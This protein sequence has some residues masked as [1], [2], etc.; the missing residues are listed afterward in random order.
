MTVAGVCII[1]INK[2]HALCQH[3]LEVTPTCAMSGHLIFPISYW[4]WKKHVQITYLPVNVISQTQC[5]ITVST[6]HT[7]RTLICTTCF[8]FYLNHSQ[9]LITIKKTL[10]IQWM[11]HIVFL[12]VPLIMEHLTF[13]IIKKN[14]LKSIPKN[15]FFTNQPSS[16]CLKN[17]YLAFQH[18]K[19]N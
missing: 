5:Y 18:V 8:D 3:T 2:W 6:Q 1:V 19:I 9:V 15:R 12:L 13:T 7:I 17:S 10:T 11:L 16:W 14:T 4:Q